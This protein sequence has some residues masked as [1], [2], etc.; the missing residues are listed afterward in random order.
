[1][2]RGIVF[3][4]IILLAVSV[5]LFAGGGSQKQQAQKPAKISFWHWWDPDSEVFC[6]TLCN[7]WTARSGIDVELMIMQDYATIL[8]AISGGNPPD[9]VMLTLKGQL[10]DMV[11]NGAAY[12][13]D[14]LIARDKIDM[15]KFLDTS[16]YG[17]K[18]NGK[19]YG[20]PF[21]G[22]N[23]GLYWNKRA[24]REAG[25]DPE[26]PP[27]TTEEVIEYAKKLTK[28]DASGKI[29]QLGFCSNDFMCAAAA[30]NT[31]YFDEKTGKYTLDNPQMVKA[32]EYLRTFYQELGI[33]PQETQNFIRS[34]G[35]YL[36]P[37]DIFQS[38]KA[39]MVTDGN[40]MV[41]F[42]KTVEYG[43]TTLP[44]SR[45]FPQLEGLNYIEYNPHF[46]P[47]G[48]KN[49]DAAWD[50]YKFMIVDPVNTVRFADAVANLPQ[51]KEIPTTF[52]SDLF[53]N[54]VWRMFVN[55]ANNKNCIP[56]PLIPLY[57]EFSSKMSEVT[58]Q[59][60]LIRN[61]DIRALLKRTEEELNS[62]L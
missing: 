54:P 39:A 16:L 13:L 62:Q 2:K 24:F 1:M 15:S 40:W 21:M 6:R 48:S 14:D 30:Y 52:Q 12:C 35:A 36:T 41:N 42:I 61:T 25:L 56:Y 34:A 37:E 5:S 55:A 38:G 46:I 31:R 7:E 32:L 29:V 10:S 49:I 26:K 28:R 17:Y 60:S 50:L 57:N 18:Y 8:T 51:L 53:N 47:S 43:A 33:D 19:Y 44:Y 23:L 58:E 20:L 27:K 9:A 3:I 22:F 59:I 11:A 45:D 4:V